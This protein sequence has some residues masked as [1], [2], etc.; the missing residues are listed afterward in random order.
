VVSR[1]SLA[2]PA[3]PPSGEF[4]EIY[5][6]HALTIA[7]WAAR[8]GGPEIDCEDVVQEVFLTVER[9]LP[10]FRGEAKLSTWL[11]RI[12]ERTVAN[13]RRKLRLRRLFA[14]AFGAGEATLRAVLTPA[15]VV[16]RREEVM[17]LYRRLD[18][19]PAKYRRTLILFEL[20]GQ[21]TKQIAE[22]LALKP[23]TVR[24]W[25]HRARAQFRAVRD[26]EANRR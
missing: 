5:R 12:T 11:F 7:R 21:S 22:L 6:E 1:V 10:E 17:A 18:R 23:G 2:P 15:E 4:S 24:V 3:A 14:R 19:L 26:K 9:R 20:E 8:L 16:E 25:L 13:H